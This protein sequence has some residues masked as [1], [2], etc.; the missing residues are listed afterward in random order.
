MNNDVHKQTAYILKDKHDQLFVCQHAP[1]MTYAGRRDSDQ[2]TCMVGMFIDDIS[3]DLEL[4]PV[5]CHYNH[6]T[7]S[8]IDTVKNIECTIV[9]KETFDWDMSKPMGDRKLNSV[10][11]EDYDT[12]IQDYNKQKIRTVKL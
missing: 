5:K 7:H 4:G 1:S 9:A 11:S 2:V 8:G 6:V 3:H 10:K 12:V